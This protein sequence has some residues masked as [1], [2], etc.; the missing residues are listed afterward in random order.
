MPGIYEK[1]TQNFGR[2]PQIKTF[3]ERYKRRWKNNIELDLK[4]MVVML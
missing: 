4:V 2:K 3:S 1:C